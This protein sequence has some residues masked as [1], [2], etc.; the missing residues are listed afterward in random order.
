ML[1]SCAGLIA[2]MLLPLVAQGTTLRLCTD[3]KSHL[4]FITPQGGGTAGMLI[5]MAAKEVGVQVE[6]YPAPVTRCREEIRVGVADGYP[7][8][9]F[10]PALEPFMKFPM[11]D[12]KPDPERAIMTARAAVFRR[13]GSTAN[14]DG[15]RF[16]HVSKPVLI[17]FGAVLLVDMLKAMEVAADDKG[18]TLGAN[19]VKLLAGRGDVAVG[20]EVSGFVLLAD[21]Q[22]KGKIE[23]LPIP[24]SAEPYYLGLNKAF[25]DANAESME[26]L[27]SAIGRIRKSPAY[28]KEHEKAVA[29]AAKELKE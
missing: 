15:R 8:A 14:W 25:Y 18:K 17:P 3:E 10:T 27:W 1:R 13:A 7:T 12:G 24:F 22:F 11:K 16:S 9:P 23:M 2:L 28:L 19:L 29:Q 5:Q 6:F 4:P 20:S 26:K 21:P